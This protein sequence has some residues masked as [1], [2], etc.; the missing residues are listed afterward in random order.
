MQ[1]VLDYGAVREV[2]VGVRVQEIPEVL[3]ESL[4]LSNRDGVIVASVDPGSPADL[5]DVRRGDV[6]RRIG[7]ESIRNFEDARR[8]LYGV[9]V[10]DRLEFMVDRGGEISVHTV[11][12]VERSR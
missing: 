5:A 6:I 7:D 2:W 9:M 10:G 4:D 11:D 1:E 12:L 3:A 8:A